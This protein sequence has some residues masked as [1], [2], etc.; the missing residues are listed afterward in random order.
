MNNRSM[1]TRNNFTADELFLGI[2]SQEYI[3]QPE[4]K[5]FMIAIEEKN[6]Q[7]I[8]FKKLIKHAENLHEK[9]INLAINILL[10]LNLLKI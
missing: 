6:V 5:H 3:Y 1:V 7:P 4:A 9:I 8:N 10:V 2:E